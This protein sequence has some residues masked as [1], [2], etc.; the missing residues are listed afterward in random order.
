ML[1]S[2][3]SIWFWFGSNRPGFFLGTTCILGV[4]MLMWLGGTPASLSIGPGG[5]FPG[6]RDLSLYAFSHEDL[7]SLL[8]NAVL[9]L[10][11][12]PCQE[13][14]WGTV[15]FITLALISIALLPALYAVILFISGG[16]ASRVCGSSPTILALFTTQCRQ[17]TQRK[18]L[19]CVPV[20]FLPWLL[21]LLNLVLLPS[22]PG[23]L[24]FCAILIGHNYCPSFIGVLQKVEEFGFFK[25]FPPW[26]YVPYY[27]RFRLPTYG[28]SQR[29]GS[30]PRAALSNRLSMEAL[31]PMNPR[32]WPMSVPHLPLERSAALS[33][34]QLLEEQMLRAGIL[35]SLQEAPEESPVKVE[36]PKSSVSS[37]RLQQLEKM[38]FP[39]D[40]AV[41]ALAA[42]T[43]L[44][45]A[46]SL[47]IDGRVGEE[48][49]MTS[50]ARGFLP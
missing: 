32:A 44:D 36:V 12:G 35:A 16:E 40:K 13:R 9:L 19:R 23:L 27:S 3:C 42:T 31:S 24:H 50:K 8:Y 21:L 29:S 20:W 43:Q 48:A 11:L 37:L 4:M 10:L 15:A 38:G 18:L 47:L 49:V 17:V 1:D 2:I 22:T 30:L 39:T 45:G 28:T 41:V 25:M 5:Q 14:R 7:P 33:E 26:V 6:Y 34:S 46:I